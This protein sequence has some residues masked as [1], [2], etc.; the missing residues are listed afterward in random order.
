MPHS[1]QDVVVQEIARHQPRL[2]GL[3][4]C[5]LARPSDVDDLIGLSAILAGLT[6]LAQEPVR[7]AVGGGLAERF[8]QLDRNGDGKVSAE[9][10]PGPLFKQ[11]DQ[12]GDGFVTLD[13][14]KAFF[15]SGPQRQRG[16]AQNPAALQ[17]GGV[18]MKTV[19]DLPYAKFEGVE[20]KLTRLDVY[21]PPSATNAPILVWVHGGG[22][23]RGDKSQVAGLP[24]AFVREGLTPY[25]D[26]MI[27]ARWAYNT[28]L[29]TF[30]YRARPGQTEPSQVTLVDT[31]TGKSRVITGDEGHKVDPW[32][33]NAPEF[34]GELL[35]AANVDSRALAI[36]RDVKHDG[37]PWQR[38]ATLTLPANAPHQTLKSVEPISGGRGAFG[39]SYFT[40]QA[41]ND[42]DKDISIWLLGFSSDGKHLIR[43]LDDGA[44]TGRVARRL[45]PESHLG[46]RELFVY[47][48]LVGDGPS[49]LHRCRTGVSQTP[50]PKMAV[51]RNESAATP[52]ARL[53]FTQ[54]CFP[55]TKD[56]NGQFTGGTEAMWLAG[57]SS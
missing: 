11:M 23:A 40:V 32:L 7:P 29:I 15:A 30:A 14:S 37:S 56:A 20:P 4:R 22:W 25:T 45:D 51:P 2:R 3:V 47:Y 5:L 52:L 17:A 57:H 21:A 13:E 35:L 18:P 28:N 49:Q 43:R 38:I 26:R 24:A 27:V 6:L 53:D 48:T 46:E 50:A 31:D 12:D 34:G 39:K 55:G 36:Y 41:G 10:F 54:D 1:T 33:W 9:E 44:Q 8:K 16:P 42:K 19:L